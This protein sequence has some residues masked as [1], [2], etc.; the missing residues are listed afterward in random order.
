MRNWSQVGCGPGEKAGCCIPQRIHK[1]EPYTAGLVIALDRGNDPR[2]DEGKTVNLSPCIGW[3]HPLGAHSF[4]G[5]PSWAPRPFLSGRGPGGAGVR[6]SSRRSRASSCVTP[7]SRRQNF[8]Q[9][10]SSRGPLPLLRATQRLLSTQ[11]GSAGAGYTRRHARPGGGNGI[12]SRPK[13]GHVNGR[14]A[15]NPTPGIAPLMPDAPHARHREV[16]QAVPILPTQA[17]QHMCVSTTAT[18]V[19]SSLCQERERSEPV[20]RNPTKASKHENVTC[21]DPRA[22]HCGCV[23]SQHKRV[24]VGI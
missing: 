11:P 12:R 4:M 2:R 7:A 5:E 15:S 21:T 17:Q 1:L 23:W 18:S 24:G 19:L 22:G 10:V 14:V 20:D 9:A 6:V 13:P 16:S 8:T 3:R